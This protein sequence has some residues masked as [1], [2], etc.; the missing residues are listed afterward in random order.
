MR[1]ILRISVFLLLVFLIACSKRPEYPRVRLQVDA[2][3]AVV[4]AERAPGRTPLR[5]AVAAVISPKATF[6]TYSPI[7][8]YLARN[9][10][11]PVELLQRPTYA[12]INELLR[13]GQADLGF[14]C[15]GAFVE[16]EREQY[17][18][19]LAVPEINGKTT[20]QALLIV[21]AAGSARELGDLRGKRFAFSD[22]L[23]NSGRLYIQ[24]RLSQMGETAD[25]F[26]SDTI[27]TYSHD[28][29]IRAVA[30]GI[31][32]GA[33]VDSLVFNALVRQEPELGV[34]LK[35]IE[36]SPGFGIPPVVVHPALDPAL[37]SELQRAL[38]TMHQ[39]AQGQKALAALYVDRFVTLETTAYDDIRE[40]ART[41]RG[42]P[43]E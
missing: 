16:G 39:D 23:S 7:L 17:M 31:V 32:D 2:Q 24:Y 33:T 25:T 11:R 30:D 28:N 40:M 15:G 4:A 9:L 43:G 12:E 27:Y 18:E 26:F 19:L 38:L 29:S 41:V 34:E 6:D 21:Q 3:G 35:V 36:R 10:D 1:H 22:P 13:T 8:D 20:Y 37:K 42:W 14:V 5:V